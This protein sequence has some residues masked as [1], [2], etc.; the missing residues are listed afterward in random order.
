L[1]AISKK[2]IDIFSK[3]RNHI[4]GDKGLMNDVTITF[5]PQEIDE[6]DYLGV[7]RVNHTNNSVE[8]FDKYILLK[9]EQFYKY[10]GQSLRLSQ[11]LK[12]IIPN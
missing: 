7:F 4:Y 9:L 8:F 3:V 6:T 12:K 1:N 5:L 10:Y 2:K 11:L